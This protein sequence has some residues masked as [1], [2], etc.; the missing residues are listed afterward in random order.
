MKKIQLLTVITALT[1][2]VGALAQVP[3]IINYQGRLS[4]GG[5]NVFNGPGQFKFALVNGGTNLNWQATAVA[6]VSGGYLTTITVSD[7]GHGYAETPAV[8]VTDSTGSNAVAIAQVTGGVVTGVA[9]PNPG[10]HYSPSPTVT[11]APPPPA[12]AYLT[13]WSNDGS[14]TGGGEPTLAVPLLVNQGLFSVNLGD[15]GL[16]NMTAIIPPSVFT[17]AAVWLRIWFSDGV[18]SFQQFYPDQRPTAGG[19]AMMAANVADGVITA[20]KLA[21]GAVSMNAI[22]ANAVSTANI[23][24]GS[25][26]AG[27]LALGAVA[28]TNLADGVITTSKITDGAVTASKLAIGAASTFPNGMAVFTS[29]GTWTR[30]PGVKTVLVKL[31]GGGGGGA[32]DIG[33]GGG[34]GYCEGVVA[35]TGDVSVSVGGGGAGSPPTWGAAGNGGVSSFLS[36]VAN[37]GGGGSSSWN[38]QGVTVS[39]GSGGGASG[40]ALVVTGQA[41]QGSPATG[42]TAGGSAGWVVNIGGSYPGSGGA[43]GGGG[44]Y[45]GGAAGVPG[46]VFV[47][48]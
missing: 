9:V 17:N 10:R 36:L 5:S 8:T 29:S 3:S 22:A 20:P 41:G 33:A 34:G 28:N 42:T 26:A 44:Q 11:I 32:W 40:G 47:Y 13:F 15:T 45:V 38:G 27:K 1:A 14:S 39:N 6:T 7:G 21:P 43:G 46:M 35:V 19:Y 25:V 12:F 23:A 31:W 18:G 24:D 4:V 2:A 30:P 37:G 16:S 48:Y